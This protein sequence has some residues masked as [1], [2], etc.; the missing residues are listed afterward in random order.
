MK[1]LA[2]F[3]LSI[4]LIGNIVFGVINGKKASHAKQELNGERYGRMVA[5]EG[6]EAAKTKLESLER[7]VQRQENKIKSLERLLKQTSESNKDLEER[8]KKMSETKANLEMRIK[9][10]EQ[11]IVQKVPANVGSGM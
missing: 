10:L 3:F 8:I 1:I 4:F 2:I 9:E 5:E 7:N 6:L 11:I